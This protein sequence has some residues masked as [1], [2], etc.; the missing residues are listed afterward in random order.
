MTNRFQLD[1]GIY[2]EGLNLEGAPIEQQ[3]VGGSE[4][5]VWHMA[6]ALCARGHRVTV[7]CFCEKPG[8]YDGVTYKPARALHVPITGEEFDLFIVSRAYHALRV[9]VRAQLRW[10]W[11]HD[12]PT[13]DQD[14][15][16]IVGAHADQ[17]LVLSDYH[18]GLFHHLHDPAM[19]PDDW[20]A[21][22][23]ALL[24]KTSN[25][26]DLELL[27][28]CAKD[29][30]RHPKRL[31][32]ASRP[33]RGLDYLLGEIFP[34]LQAIEPDLELHVCSYDASRLPQLTPEYRAHCQRLDAHMANTPGI[35]SH[36]A[37][38]KKAYYHLLA[39]ASVLLCPSRFPEISCIAALEAQ[40][41]GVPV[42]ATNDF[43]FPE[44]V[45]YSGLEVPGDVLPPDSA[46][47]RAFV[48]RTVAIL[49]DE[50]LHRRLAHEGK[51][52]VEQ[53]YQ[54]KHVAEAWE[55]HAFEAFEARH[56]QHGR[57]ICQ[58]LIY[59]SAVIAAQAMA[60]DQG[61]ED[62]VAETATMLAGHHAD[63]DDYNSPGTT[64]RAN[65]DDPRT[66]LATMAARLGPVDPQQRPPVVL[67]VGCGA[68]A[69]M[70]YLLK[71]YPT[72][73][74][75]G[76]DF[77]P[78]L[79]ASTQTFIAEQG[80]GTRGRADV[81]NAE[82]GTAPVRP[83]GGYDAV[84]AGE[85]LEHMAD[86]A[87]FIGQ[88]EEYCTV[89]GRIILSVPS[90]PW[91]SM[92]F[93]TDARLATNRPHLQDFH[94][95]DLEAL[96]GAKDDLRIEYL[97]GAVSARNEPLGWWLVSYTNRKGR[98]TGVPDYARRWLTERPYQRIA[99]SMI[100]KDGANDLRRAL[101]SVL[102]VVD[103]VHIAI[104]DRTT[105][106][107]RDVVREFE[108]RYWPKVQVST[109][110]FA[111]FAQARNVALEGVDADWVLILDAD[112]AVSNARFLRLYLEGQF[113]EGFAIT[114][115]HL[116]LDMQ[117]KGGI[118]PDKPTRLFRGDRGY[119]WWGLIH[120]DPGLGV[121]AEVQPTLILPDVR[122]LHH[123][124]SDEAIRRDKAVRRN[125]D[126]LRRDRREHPE[127]HKGPFLVLRDMMSLAQLGYEAT[128]GVFDADSVRFIRESCLLYLE[129]YR[130]PQ[131]PFHSAALPIY[132]EAL[133]WL[134]AHGLEVAPGW[135]PPVQILY[136]AAVSRQAAFDGSEQLPPEA[137]WFANRDEL[138]DFMVAR[139]VHLYDALDPCAG[140]TRRSTVLP[141]VTAAN[142]TGPAADDGAAAPGNEDSDGSAHARGASPER[143]QASGEA[144]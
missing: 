16:G 4:S 110:T 97:A 23:A 73:V 99:L 74:V 91:E 76:I 48:D 94:R 104:D 124:Y 128:G 8:K 55:T 130:D 112:E 88:L 95:R 114:Q 28:R 79:I 122:I 29:V 66:R 24:W 121:N 60:R 46:Y 144:G 41:L 59:Q 101:Q 125:M 105:D 111:D 89:G 70:G 139:G 15:I 27:R 36:G 106:T 126:L 3:S 47:T 32:F 50:V 98:S 17:V 132:Q 5:A 43:A 77:S 38:T 117:A 25:G 86:P 19:R 135:G 53:R 35:T 58:N 34:K 44:T 102:P 96:F 143:L 80:W 90:G 71:N 13:N 138:R 115:H 42:V 12:V 54:W 67:D 51:T 137:R 84:F 140:L 37:L 120:E 39:S 7:F 83:A 52:H 57:R 22:M 134:N 141:F 100:V 103:S 133:R 30:R 118:A 10:L 49:R 119:R 78:A 64:D 65:W 93:G 129:R 108:G 11:T 6:R 62:L 20:H 40:A 131:A 14:L 92:S 75:H 1:I 56:A 26:V 69:L 61:Y 68:G 2:A 127:R 81:V 136:R 72:L 18:A 142:G 82:S 31:I 109:V 123:G 45:A 33:E 63:P 107:S 87:V 113:F 116:T 21:H 85:I 9:P